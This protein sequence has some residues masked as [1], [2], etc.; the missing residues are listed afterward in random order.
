MGYAKN[1]DDAIGL[2]VEEHQ[3]VVS[4]LTKLK[5]DAAKI[6]EIQKY[7]SLPTQYNYPSEISKLFQYVSADSLDEVKEKHL[8]TIEQ[9]KQ[10][11]LK[12]KVENEK[13][14][15]NNLI[16]IQ[17]IKAYMSTIGIPEYHH[18]RDPKS[19][20]RWPKQIKV[21]SGYLQDI[22]RYIPIGDG[23]SSAIASADAAAKAVEKSAVE[24]LNTITELENIKLAD[25]AEKEKNLLLA[26]MILKYQ[27]DRDQTDCMKDVIYQ[28]IKKD[29]YLYLAH[30]L[31]LNRGDWNDGSSY[32]E[33][34][35]EG[36]VPETDQEQ[37]IIAS[38]IELCNNDDGYF[39][40]RVFRDCQWNYDRLYG[41]AETRNKDLYQDYNRLVQYK[42]L[43]R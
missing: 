5:N 13:A 31:R 7:P 1:F 41:I 17:T 28:L 27:L 15:N 3:R 22:R 16:T 11:V 34:G 38:L 33:T 10:S 36:F 21:E 40:G 19:R 32:A 4:E 2:V 26:E 18:I 20:A 43:E 6:M 39:D 25:K 9:Y 14:I 23:Y 8:A 24:R 42:A 12:I 30:Y 29:K 35:I 37:Q